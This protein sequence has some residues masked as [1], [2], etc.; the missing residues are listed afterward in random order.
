MSADISL[1]QAFKSSSRQSFDTFREGEELMWNYCNSCARKND[2][3]INDEM[4]SAMG[5]DYPFWDD[6]LV[7]VY[8]PLRSWD[9]S[10]QDTRDKVICTKYQSR[11]GENIPGTPDFHLPLLE[12][13]W[14]QMYLFTSL[15][16]RG[17]QVSL[18]H[19]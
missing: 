13:R 11:P 17:S 8:A 2:C 7:R 15:Q 19:S 9:D 3:P 10:Y 18:A 5:N 4:R 12:K 16:E 6:S 14:G 1:P